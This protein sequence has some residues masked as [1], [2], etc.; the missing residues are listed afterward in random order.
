[1]ESLP[2]FL[3]HTRLQKNSKHEIPGGA[4][5]AE[6]PVAG[7]ADV[8]LRISWRSFCFLFYPPQSPCYHRFLS[9]R[10]P[11]LRNGSPS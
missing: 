1:M 4:S 6:G 9:I 11:F 7:R 2:T 8:G 10:I 5:L 3:M